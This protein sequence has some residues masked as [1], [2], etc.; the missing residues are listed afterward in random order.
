MSEVFRARLFVGPDAARAKDGVALVQ[1]PVRKIDD[2]KRQKRFGEP[3][4]HGTNRDDARAAEF[5]KLSCRFGVPV[6]RIPDR[7]DEE[8]AI[9]KTRCGLFRS[10]YGRSVHAIALTL[11]V[12][13][14][15]SPGAPPQSI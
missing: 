6:L 10:K 13:I 14:G 12:V 4:I 2:E 3:P 15:K 8:R 7:D 5:A 1:H 11:G 9:S